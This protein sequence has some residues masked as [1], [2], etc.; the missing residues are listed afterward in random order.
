MTRQSYTPR[1]LSLVCSS[2]TLTGFPSV[3]SEIVDLLKRSPSQCGGLDSSRGPGLGLF[4]VRE[5]VNAHGGDVTVRCVG[6]ETT[7]AVRLPRCKPEASRG[8]ITLEADL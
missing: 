3:L 8:T 1:Q 2:R 7:F 5:I 6:E 4:V